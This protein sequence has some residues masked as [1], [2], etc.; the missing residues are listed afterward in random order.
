[1]VKLALLLLR[2]SLEEGSPGGAERRALVG[3]LDPRSKVKFGSCMAER[4]ELV[5]SEDCTDIAERGATDVHDEAPDV[6]VPGRECLFDNA[7]NPPA[8]FCS[9]CRR[10]M[11]GSPSDPAW[12]AAAAVCRTVEVEV[13]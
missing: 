13:C 5:R 7:Q 9:S 11:V 10:E 6:V 8:R 12:E 2:S 4:T 1:M 3:A